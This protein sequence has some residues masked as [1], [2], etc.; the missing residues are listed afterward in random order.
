MLDENPY[1]SPNY[2]DPTPRISAMQ[3]AR[4]AAATVLGCM[5]MP[6]GMT[7]ALVLAAVVTSITIYFFLL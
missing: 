2:E 1:Q 3:A 7:A 4:D 5:M 6:F